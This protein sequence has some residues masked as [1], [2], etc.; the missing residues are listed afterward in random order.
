M[1]QGCVQV[2]SC[3]FFS[4]FSQVRGP[5]CVTKS[6]GAGAVAPLALFK[7]PLRVFKGGNYLIIL[8]IE[9]ALTQEGRLFKGALIRGF[10]ANGDMIVYDN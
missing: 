8:S 9:W 6:A 10:I 7:P 5:F 4:I 3:D 1:P 2:F